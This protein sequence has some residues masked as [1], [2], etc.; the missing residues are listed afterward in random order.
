MT[1]AQL[2]ELRVKLT[3]TQ[4]QVA[5]LL[6]MRVSTRGRNS[7]QAIQVGS[8]EAGRVRI[9]PAMAELLRAKLHLLRTEQATFED[10]IQY[11]L[12]ELI[13]DIYS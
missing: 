13:R 3:L 6:H 7:G 2:Q 1:G 10:L 4:V 9:P 8:W 5:Q 11:S 12:D